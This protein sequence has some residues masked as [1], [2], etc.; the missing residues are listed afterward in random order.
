MDLFF[1]Y[2][3]KF[4]ARFFGV[5]RH[6]PENAKTLIWMI[7]L[8]DFTFALSSPFINVF[9]FRQHDDWNVALSFNVVQFVF[10]PI[11]FWIGGVLSPRF[12]HRVSY[13]LGFIFYSLL[14]LALLLLR[15]T[16]PD[17]CVP[18]G[19]LSGLA[20]GFYYLGQHAL[21]MDLTRPK[22]RDYFFS[23]YLLLSSIL[24]IPAPMLAGWVIASYN[25]KFLQNNGSLIGYY[26]IFGFT[27]VIY[28]V[29][30]AQSFRLRVPHITAG[31]SVRKVLAYE[32]GKDWKGLLASWFF[33]GVRGGVFWFV[34]S[35]FVYKVWNNELAVGNFNTLQTF[36]AV[37][38]AYVLSRWEGYQN[39]RGGMSL[40]SVLIVISTFVLAVSMGPMA[41]LLFGILYAVGATWFQVGFSAISFNVIEHERDSRQRKLEYFTL[42]ELP[43]ALGRL[44]G[45]ALFWFG[46][47][48]FGG[49]GLRAALVLLGI[50]QWGTYWFS[51][52]LAAKPS[53][54]R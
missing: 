22:D 44:V 21:T 27:L 12:G 25:P 45:L 3:Y 32:W 8:Y 20:I 9:L 10:V 2:I 31:F 15:E 39:R 43:L 28:L 29:L 47:Y 49:V 36:L 51:R 50:S 30:I 24:K 17:Y 23:L 35:L 37:V 16:A 4:L 18:L 54:G 13:Q 34:T 42:R 33:S 26:L 53:R 6:L 40:S 52:N 14:L 46:L 11:G 48:R 19:V 1:S 41:L 7:A 38:T 5:R